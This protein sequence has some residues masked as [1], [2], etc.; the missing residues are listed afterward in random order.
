V[1]GDDT[2]GAPVLEESRMKNET[3]HLEFSFKGI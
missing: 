1:G 3:M 2:W